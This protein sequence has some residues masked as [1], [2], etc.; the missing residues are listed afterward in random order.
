MR[1]SVVVVVDTVVVDT[2]VAVDDQQR[3]GH[4]AGGKESRKVGRR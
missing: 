4:T 2:V 1:R 3:P